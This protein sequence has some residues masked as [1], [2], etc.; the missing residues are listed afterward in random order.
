MPKLDIFLTG[1]ISIWNEPEWGVFSTQ[2]LIDQVNA[3]PDDIE[4]ISLIINSPGGDVVEGFAMYDYLKSLGK[5]ITTK[6][7][8]RVASIATVVFLAGDERMIAENTEFMIHNPWTFAE[9][10]ADE[11]QKR[12]DEL[13][14]I[15]NQIAEFYAGRIDGDKDVLLELMAEET[16]FTADQAIEMG[17]ATSTLQ[18]QNKAAI[19]TKIFAGGVACKATI[20]LNCNMVKPKNPTMTQRIKDLVGRIKG[21]D[22]IKA[23]DVTLESG[24][25]IQ[26]ETGDRQEIAVGD[27]V[28]VNGNPVEDGTWTLSDGTTFTTADGV[29]SELTPAES[30]DEGDGEE[31]A[32]DQEALL[33]AVGA[34]VTEAIKPVL[35]FVDQQKTVNKEQA[36]LNKNVTEAMELI[37]NGGFEASDDET[38]RPKNYVNRTGPTGQPKTDEEINDQVVDNLGKS[39]KDLVAAQKKPAAVTK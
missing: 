3:A 6:G 5:K 9:G 10:D 33:E 25:V 21:Q 34:A 18:P 13:R 12:A 23:L 17:F 36:D 11:M 8:G 29:I 4:E 20:N 38:H 37:G 26:V 35:D 32:I 39:V 16:T 24:D 22:Q 30:G 7:V 2:H 1:E 27:A 14:A 19:K 28:T 31:S 15:E